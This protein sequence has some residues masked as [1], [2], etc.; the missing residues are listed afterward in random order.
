[1]ERKILSFKQFLNEEETEGTTG[2]SPT[3]TQTLNR[4]ETERETKSRIAKSIVQSIF[5]EMGTTGGV[6]SY[7]EQTKEVKESLPYKGCGV[8]E[9]YKLEKAPL[10]VMTIK[11]IL[12]YLQEK[13]AGNY[14][15]VI[16]ELN[17]KRSVIIGIRNR[18]SLK[19]ETSNQ[20]RFCDALYFIP[21]NAKDG[22]ETSG[23]TGATGASSDFMKQKN[24]SLNITDLIN[25]R[26]LELETVSESGLWSF[27]DF[28][29]MNKERQFLIENISLLQSGEISES[30]FYQLYEGDFLGIGGLLKGAYKKGKQVFR[31]VGKKI[32]LVDDDDAKKKKMIDVDS[33]DDGESKKQTQTAVPTGPT[34]PIPP[35]DLGDKITPYQI[36]TVPSLAYYGKKPMNPKGVG[37]KLPG[38]TLYILQESSLGSE[39]KYK[40][41]V[42]GEKISVG[43]YPIGVTKFETYK[44]AEI[45]TENCGM[46]IHRSSTKG[47]GVCVGPWSA[48]CQVFSDNEE[49]KEFISK[50]EKESMNAGKFL[51]ALIQLDDIP[52]EVLK[53]AIIGLPYNNTNQEVVQQSTTGG[54]AQT[55]TVKP[56]SLKK[57][58]RIT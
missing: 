49:W 29:N 5:G 2:S 3:S 30:E 22:T 4:P 32:G 25:Q 16:S 35:S 12:N 1:M 14:T 24:E 15:R 20:D 33:E 38:D 40:M 54:T 27:E 42:E 57:L 13:K 50:A 46:Q 52:D 31:W 7:I 47:V 21:G 45:Y 44:P 48:G 23:G 34:G 37:I 53:T 39:T 51:Y 36:T 58:G 56:G 26:I 8:N 9:P 18:I 17:E 41:M 28:E 10:S 55:P 19:K 6:D 43:R 11:I